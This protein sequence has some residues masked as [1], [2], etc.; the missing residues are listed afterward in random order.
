MRLIRLALLL[1]LGSFSLSAHAAEPHEVI[2]AKTVMRIPR[3]S[4]NII[5]HLKVEAIRHRV[6]LKVEHL[7]NDWIGFTT[8]HSL[9]V[10]GPSDKVQA[11]QS[12]LTRLVNGR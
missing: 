4:G 1:C 8:T 11:F 5:K 7:A 6:D 10:T 2:T 3:G 12:A 9:E